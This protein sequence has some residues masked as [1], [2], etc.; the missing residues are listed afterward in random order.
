M[1]SR[2]N[3]VKHVRPLRELLQSVVC[4]ASKSNDSTS[5][6]ITFSHAGLGSLILS[7][8][9]FAS[10]REVFTSLKEDTGLADRIS[11]KSIERAL[12]RAILSCADTSNQGPVEEVINRAIAE[13]RKALDQP[14]RKFEVYHPVEGLEEADLPQNL[15][16]VA[17]TVF[18]DNH[19]N[20][21]R[22]VIQRQDVSPDEKRR[23]L[24]LFEDDGEVSSLLGKSI[25][26]VRVA[27]ID[28]GAARLRAR[29]EIESTLEVIN[30]FADLVDYNSAWV[31]LPGDSYRGG[32]TVLVNH[33]GPEP[34][35]AVLRR[36][37]GPVGHL[38]LGRLKENDAERRLGF[39]EA[40]LLLASSR[41]K[42]DDALL[43]AMRWA[44]RA[45]VERR[46]ETAFLLYAIALESIML[47]DQNRQELL[48]RLR[49]RTAHLLGENPT[50]RKRISADLADL[51]S[52]RS[53]IVHNGRF[54]VTDSDLAGMRAYCKGSII[55]L[56]TTKEFG[57]IS[58]PKD[59]GQFWDD[60]CL[61]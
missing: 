16:N 23:Q 24:R 53:A 40:C 8:S 10:Y 12:Q 39:R 15:G 46:K 13:F 47:S 49:L 29:V 58:S 48:H 52:I 9:H 57:A 7:G 60:R 59:F 44:G 26:I 18:A 55:R 27:T 30:F 20:A 2:K 37:E 14:L 43:G 22:E 34:L 32:E 1:S 28:T 17:F 31:S 41:N 51:Y 36:R 5:R 38:P 6:Q 19:V 42:I 54:E 25:A 45:S 61:A 11:A 56:L 33:N 50:E 3:I 35:I 4:S 21:Q